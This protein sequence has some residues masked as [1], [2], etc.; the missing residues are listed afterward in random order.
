[1]REFNNNELQ[2]QCL[3]ISRFYTFNQLEN[4]MEEKRS[5]VTATEKIKYI[6]IMSKGETR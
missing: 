2:N 1:M 6:Y 4:L 3:K 5:Y